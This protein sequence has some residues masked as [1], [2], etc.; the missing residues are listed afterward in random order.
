M[1][2]REIRNVLGGVPL[3]NPEV[4]EWIDGY[5]KEGLSEINI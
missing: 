4:L 5:I 3:D 2:T 1:D